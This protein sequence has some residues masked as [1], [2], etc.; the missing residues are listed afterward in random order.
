LNYNQL[1]LLIL[2]VL[3][4]VG[5]VDSMGIARKLESKQTRVEIHA[6]RMALM[7]YHKLGLL[8]RERQEGL[9]VYSLSERGAG[10]LRWLQQTKENT[11][12]T[13]C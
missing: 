9:L 11:R 1:K 4:E 8:K 7:R 2:E 10:R 3:S 6:L 5:P 12:A 13:L